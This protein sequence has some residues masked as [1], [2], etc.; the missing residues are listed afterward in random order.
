MH[1]DQPI[2]L[3]H[4]LDI[5]RDAVPRIQTPILARRLANRQ[6]LV[7]RLL[8]DADLGRQLREPPVRLVARLVDDADVEVLLLVREE[9][10]AVGV[11]F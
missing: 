7:H 2:H 3:H 5:R 10:R 6:L 4:H 8:I 1:A 9:R 11:E